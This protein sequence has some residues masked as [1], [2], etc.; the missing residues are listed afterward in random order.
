MIKVFVL[1]VWLSGGGYGLGY[2]PVFA[3]PNLAECMEASQPYKRIVCVEVSVPK[4]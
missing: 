2:Q 1:F 4:R 3:Y